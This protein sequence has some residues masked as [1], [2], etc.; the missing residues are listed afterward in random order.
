MGQASPPAARPPARNRRW[1]FF[2]VVLG[3]LAA[4]AA[5]V[6]V[7]FNLRQ[8][9][10]PE[11]LAEAQARWREHGLR[12]YDLEY[13][14]KRDRDPNPERYLVLV[15]NRRIVLVAADGEV[16][17]FDPTLGMAAG[18][19]AG[20]FTANAGADVEEIFAHIED[21]L[22]AD[23]E[24]GRRNYLVALFDAHDGH[25]RRFVYRVRHS[26]RREEWNVLLSPPGQSGRSDKARR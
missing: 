23:A 19:P 12:S 18:L 20:A 8:Q 3:L 17:R 6:P 25:P 24:S 10:R 1:V 15:R 13:T 5:A 4:V 22:R 14:I 11:Q 21:L 16:V 7:V 9:L 2:F 26:N